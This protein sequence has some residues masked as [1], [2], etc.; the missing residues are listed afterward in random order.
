MLASR[1]ILRLICVIATGGLGH[2]RLG[3]MLFVLTVPL[4]CQR[5]RCVQGSQ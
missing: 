1:L 3:S 5:N 2:S 4:T